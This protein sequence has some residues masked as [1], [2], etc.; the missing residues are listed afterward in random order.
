MGRPWR[1]RLAVVAVCGLVAAGA[2]W[3]I[4][5]DAP[6][7]TKL[8]ASAPQVG[9]CWLVDPT[10]AQATLP[11]PGGP[12][13]C[14]K[15]HTAE[16]YHVGQVDADLV[17]RARGAKGD[18]TTIATNLMYAQARRACDAI[19]R[20]YLGADWHQ[21]QV[22]L[23]ASWIA[24]ARDGFFGCALAQT[25]DPGGTRYVSRTASLKG[26]GTPP[27]LVIECVTKNGGA[28]A[29]SPC[30]GAHDG[31][32]VGTYTLTPPDAPF[33]ATAV[34]AA[35]TKGCGQE[36]LKYLGLPTDAT[37]PDLHVGYVGP[38]TAAT[39]L[40]SDQ[41]FACYTTAEVR[42]RGTLR[43]LGTRPLPT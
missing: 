38:T 5:R 4:N 6:V 21:D 11:W 24:P 27:A 31:E 3:W 33:N 13:D 30:D 34:A 19:G 39:W 20:I 32:F 2:V 23:L 26:L 42:M 22:T 41:T 28:L 14:A 43:N 10:A 1:V 8:P 18:E 15:P 17:R 37:R 12:L 25:V 16:V 7:P 40:G 35:V 29:Y 36:A 9:S